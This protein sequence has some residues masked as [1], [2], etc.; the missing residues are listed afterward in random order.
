MNPLT[1]ILAICTAITCI[2]WVFVHFTFFLI[3]NQPLLIGESN[4]LLLLGEWILV[5][6]GFSAFLYYVAKE[7]F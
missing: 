2:L 6:L 3:Y 7:V 1:T 4:T 5:L